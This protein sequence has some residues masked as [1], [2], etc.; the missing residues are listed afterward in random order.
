MDYFINLTL[1]LTSFFF[2]AGFGAFSAISWQEKEQRAAKLA[3]LV[4]IIGSALFVGI[5][6]LPSPIPQ[7]AAGLIALG[8]ATGLV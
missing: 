2:L 5:I 3:I 8:A 6:F 7:I 4:A 1:S